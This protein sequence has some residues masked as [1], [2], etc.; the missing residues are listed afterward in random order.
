MLI[1]MTVPTKS[2]RF[3]TDNFQRIFI[4]VTWALLRG[5][6][7]GASWWTCSGRSLRYISGGGLINRNGGR[8]GRMSAMRGG[9][10]GR[11]CM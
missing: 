10:E 7:L 6:D 11:V 2:T 3:L 9:G 1:I 5:T 8:G 4:L